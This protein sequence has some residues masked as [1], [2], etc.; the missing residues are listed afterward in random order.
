[1]CTALSLASV[2]LTQ[3]ELIPKMHGA[4][5][6]CQCPNKVPFHMS[7]CMVPAAKADVERLTK[8]LHGLISGIEPTGGYSCDYC[9]DTHVMP[10]TGYACTRCPSP[11]QECRRGGN[12]PFCETTPCPCTCH[13]KN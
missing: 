12:G 4:Q 10:A 13:K 5:L 1:M 9:K 6:A 8:A 7:N 11:C 2:Y 3:P